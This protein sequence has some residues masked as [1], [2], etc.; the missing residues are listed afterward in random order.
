MLAR[1]RSGAAAV[2]VAAAAARG[3]RE[4]DA[5]SCSS[6][7]GSPTS[8]PVAARGVLL[9]QALLRD[10]GEPALLRGD[11]AP[12]RAARCAACW[13]RSS[14]DRGRRRRAR[15][16]RRLVVGRPMQTGQLE[17]TLLPK[18]LALPIFASDPLSSVA[19]ATESALVVLLAVSATVGA[20]RLPDLDRDRRAARDRRRL[21]HADRA[22]LRDERRRLHRRAR[23]PRHAA[24]PRR[25]RRAP[26]RLRADGRRLDLGRDLRDHV[27]RAVARSATRSRLSLACLAADRAR[28]P[29]RRARVGARSSRC[30][31]TSSSRR[32]ACS[33]SSASSSSR[34]GTRTTPSRRTRCRSAPARSRSSSSCARSRRARPRSPASR[35]SRT[36]STRSAARTARTPRA[37]LAVLGVIAIT[38]FLGVS[39][40]AVHLHARPSATD[41]VVSQI[42]RAVFPPGSP[43]ELH[44]LRRPGP[45]ADRAGPRREHVVPGLPAPLG[46]ARARPLRAAAVHEPRRPARLL[47]RD[48]RARRRRR[49]AALD[50][51]REHEQPHPPLR[52][53]RLHRVHALAG[54]DGAVLA[55]RAR[56][57]LAREGARQRRRRDGDRRRHARRR[58][59]EVR[60]GRLARHRRDPAARAR[61]CSASAGTTCGSRA[62]CAPARPRSSPRRR[63]ATRRSLVV[64]SLDDATD[65]ALRVRAR[66]LDRR[67]PRRARADAQHRS[68]DP[69]ALVQAHRHAARG[70]RRARSASPRRCSSRSGGC[71][72]ASRTSSP[73]SSRSCSRR[74]RSLEQARHPHELALKL[75]LLAEPGV[76]VADVPVRRAA[77]RPAEPRAARRPRPRLRRQ[78][79]VD[80]RRQL[81]ETLGVDDVR[82]VHFAFSG[83]DAAEIREEWAAHGPRDPARGRRGAVPRHRPAAARLP[84]RA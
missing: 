10:A 54:R 43:C 5:A 66:D 8:S 76:V 51:R 74:R 9:A 44:V 37:T 29:A 19:Y 24:E 4:R 55:R 62:G 2:G 63:R 45:D 28:E 67:R 46:A 27:V 41:S 17:E 36:A 32:S 34:P 39:Y 26:H 69:A 80:A 15:R 71:R 82:A 21:V 59:H 1:A 13:G 70:A 83:E 20:P 81:R 84:A 7:G 35:R 60:R 72:A 47:E 48:A 68:R 6:R 22:R 40:L 50:L 31:R 25:R 73:S 23:E 77:G 18:T 78:R 52:D 49:A 64:E 14:R 75:R 57:A 53:R 65:A 38:L 11:G 61:R 3:P 33:S 16:V 56:R 30:R 12:A 42:A 79:R 58:L